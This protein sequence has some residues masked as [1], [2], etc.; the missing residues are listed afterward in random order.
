VAHGRE[1]DVGGIAGATFEVAATEVTFGL[2]V[3]DEEN[4][5]GFWASWPRYHLST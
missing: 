2:Q 4:A 1:D 3:S 5:T